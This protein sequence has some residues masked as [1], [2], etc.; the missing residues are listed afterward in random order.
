MNVVV[1]KVCI[2]QLFLRQSGSGDG[3]CDL[4]ALIHYITQL[5]RD[6]ERAATSLL[7]IGI[8]TTDDRL[9]FNV[10]RRTSH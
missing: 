2:V 8:L 1:I 6:L 10:Q 7:S 9:S 5:A 3:I 4:S